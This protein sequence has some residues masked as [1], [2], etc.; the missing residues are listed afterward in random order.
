MFLFSNL[1]GIIGSFVSIVKSKYWFKNNLLACLAILDLFLAL[2][3]HQNLFQRKKD[4]DDKM[5]S[6]EQKENPSIFQNI[7]SVYLSNRNLINIYLL[8]MSF[9]ITVSLCI[10]LVSF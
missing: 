4:T 5:V 7:T 2:L 10:M 8:Y 6:I 3:G 9:W 1:G